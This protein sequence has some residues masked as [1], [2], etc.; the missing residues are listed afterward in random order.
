[1]K[2]N[3]EYQQPYPLTPQR[4]NISFGADTLCENLPNDYLK[5]SLGLKAMFQ[6]SFALFLSLLSLISSGLSNSREGRK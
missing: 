3:I 2:K 1:M 5:V 4:N 6:K